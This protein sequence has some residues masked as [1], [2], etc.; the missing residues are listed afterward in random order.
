MFGKFSLDALATCAFGVD[1]QSFSNSESSPFVYHAQ[2]IFTN[3]LVSGV[4]GMLRFVPGVAQIF[5]A[6]NINIL[7]PK[8]VTFF[9]DVVLQTLKARKDSKDKRND[10][11]DMILD[12][13]KDENDNEE[14]DD[15]Q[16]QR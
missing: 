3:D 8:S 14:E 11:I 13:S 15:D 7:H 9:R 4:G 16:Y 5:K 6:L 1:A 12:C 10:L 2:Q